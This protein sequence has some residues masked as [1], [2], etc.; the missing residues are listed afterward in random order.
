MKFKLKK[1][2]HMNVEGNFHDTGERL[3]VGSHRKAVG[4]APVYS[5]T[6]A[7]DSVSQV[8]LTEMGTFQ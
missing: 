5:I 3:L 6:L 8:N 2:E 1:F 7:S 4:L